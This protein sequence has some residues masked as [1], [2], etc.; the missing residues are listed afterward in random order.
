MKRQI[1][2]T[3]LLCLGL[4]AA[5]QDTY[6]VTEAITQPFEKISIDSGCHVKIVMGDTNLLTV[7]TLSPDSLALH[8]VS[9]LGECSWLYVHYSPCLLSDSAIILT[10]NATPSKIIVDRN[11]TLDMRDCNMNLK[12]LRIFADEDNQILLNENA[13]LLKR[14]VITSKFNLAIGMPRFSLNW[15]INNPLSQNSPYATDG[16]DFS[17]ELPIRTS[18]PL[19]RRWTFLTGATLSWTATP[20]ANNVTYS[21]GALHL[22]DNATATTPN[23]YL[24]HFDV[25]MPLTFQYKTTDGSNLGVLHFGLH[26]SHIFNGLLCTHILDE[27]RKWI[28]NKTKQKI[29]I[30]NPWQISIHAGMTSPILNYYDLDVYF[31]LLPTYAPSTGVKIHEFGIAFTI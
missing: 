23:N 14:H 21:D 12:G 6:V 29:D 3:L 16:F 27:D 18:F 7:Q 20:L 28:D 25:S 24:R 10:L 19:S 2:T 5:A 11:A 15:H 17:I 31:N 30:L 22:Q 26:F 4:Y 9:D 1:I 8:P 13:G